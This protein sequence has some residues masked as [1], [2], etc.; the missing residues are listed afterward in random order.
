[1][2][3]MAC[4]AG[5]RLARPLMR[6]ESAGLFRALARGFPGGG[7]PGRLLRT[8]LARGARARRFTLLAQFLE[9]RTHVFSVFL[10]LGQDSFH[11]APRAR[12][13]FAEIADELAV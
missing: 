6:I 7:L 13:V 9:Q 11:H 12:V 5:N 2:A 1:M 10:F 4:T 3:A 8:T